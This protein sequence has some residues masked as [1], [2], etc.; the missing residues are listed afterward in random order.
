MSFYR[1]KIL[2]HYRNPRNFG[3]LEN[4]DTSYHLDNPLCGDVVDVYL[5]MR[6]TIVEDVRFT[7]EGC[8]ISIAAMS[9]LTDAVKNKDIAVVQSMGADDITL[10]LGIP[11]TP[12]RINC[13][14]LGLTALQACLIHKNSKKK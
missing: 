5:K 2:D 4:A 3:E 9:M 1:E 10:L 6:N 13:A 11:L 8:A 12:S 7:A 14:L